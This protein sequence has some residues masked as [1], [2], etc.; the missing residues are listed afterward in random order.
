MVGA[1][2]QPERDPAA[3]R[4]KPE[5]QRPQLI[6]SAAAQFILVPGRPPQLREVGPPGAGVRQSE[7]MAVARR[8]GR[9]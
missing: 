2:A 9:M 1:A 7:R 5:H 3:G 6:G 8:R 4:A